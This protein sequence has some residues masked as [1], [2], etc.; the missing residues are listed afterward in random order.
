MVGA[1]LTSFGTNQ[2]EPF[3]MALDLLNDVLQEVN[4][5]GELWF[6]LSSQVLAYVDSPTNY[7]YDLTAL[8]IDPR[9]IKRVS[10]TVSPK[11]DVKRINWPVF[12]ERFRG[13]AT[14]IENAPSHYAVFGDVLEF[15]TQLDKDYG[16]TIEYYA[17]MPRVTAATDTLLIPERD[18]D[19]IEAGVL[20]YLK[21]RIAM[22]DSLTAVALYQQSLA[23]L[24][25]DSK[26]DDGAY[27]VRPARF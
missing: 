6:L 24:V 1:E 3:N 17:D 4:R 26:K 12:N 22:P 23:R 2:N 15:S 11:G 20:A 21:T 18:E 8:S 9:R 7:R 13:E 14:I 25:Y 19:V 5:Q 27:F 10:R 16:M